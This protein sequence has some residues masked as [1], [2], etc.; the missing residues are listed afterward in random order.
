[1]LRTWRKSVMGCTFMGQP[2]GKH[3]FLG[4]RIKPIIENGTGAPTEGLEIDI[5]LKLNYFL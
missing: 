5:L 3:V 4:E 2:P 1:M